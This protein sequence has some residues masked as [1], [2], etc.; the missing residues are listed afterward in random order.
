MLGV[1]KLKD[2]IDSLEAQNGQLQA[3][4]ERVANALGATEERLVATEADLTVW[5]A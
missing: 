5:K 1:E 4:V 3:L 2:R